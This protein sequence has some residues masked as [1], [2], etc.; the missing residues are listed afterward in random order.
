[1]R[2][3]KCVGC[4]R[5]WNIVVRFLCLD[6]FCEIF[7]GVEMVLKIVL[8]IVVFFFNRFIVNM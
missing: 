3:V 7:L 8:D 1:M 6:G 5:V 2:I 4:L